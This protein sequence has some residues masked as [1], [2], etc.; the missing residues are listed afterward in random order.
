MGSQKF[1]F[2]SYFLLL[3]KFYE[4]NRKMSFGTFG[5]HDSR[6]CKK[7]KKEEGGRKAKGL[8]DAPKLRGQHPTC[9]RE[10]KYYTSPPQQKWI[11][12]PG[13][14]AVSPVTLA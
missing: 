9:G 13:S 4:E 11:S 10:I 5:K 8:H 1:S 6:M 3:S 14:A 2:S 7:K 12:S